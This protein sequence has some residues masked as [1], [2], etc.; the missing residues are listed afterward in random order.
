MN[1]REEL[2]TVITMHCVL[3]HLAHD[4]LAEVT[5][6]AGDGFAVAV[7]RFLLRGSQTIDFLLQSL[8]SWRAIRKQRLVA[9]TEPRGGACRSSA[10]GERYGNQHAYDGG[11]SLAHVFNSGFNC[12]L[13]V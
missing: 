6:E 7:A 8:R 9:A 2:T 11:C 3:I 1:V 10:A 4:H 12:W 13:V 5:L